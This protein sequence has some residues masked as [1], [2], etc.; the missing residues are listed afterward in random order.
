MSQCPRIV[1]TKTLWYFASNKPREHYLQ[2][3]CI[4]D[5]ILTV[6][7]KELTFHVLDTRKW[8]TPE[9]NSPKFTK[10]KRNL[11]LTPMHNFII[12]TLSLHLSFNLGLTCVANVSVRVRRKNWD[13]SAITRLKTLATQADLGSKTDIFTDNLL[14]H[15]TLTYIRWK[16]SAETDLFKNAIQNGDFWERR[17]FVYM[18][19]DENGGFRIQW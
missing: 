19:T 10:N 2:K 13:E 15:S 14:F 17:L 16:R 7:L 5:L 1:T 8:R 6:R 12:N 4:R 11:W 9:M 3:H 18:W